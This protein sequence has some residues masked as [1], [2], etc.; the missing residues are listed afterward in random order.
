MA[1]SRSRKDQ[2]GASDGI[3]FMDRNRSPMG[4]NLNNAA[5]MYSTWT[6]F[7]GMPTQ[8]MTDTTAPQIHWDTFSPSSSP[9]FDQVY[10]NLD[11]NAEYL[12]QI[13]TNIRN[14][15][16]G[17]ETD[18]RLADH[19]LHGNSSFHEASME[20]QSMYAETL[21]SW[22]NVKN[23]DPFGTDDVLKTS[24]EPTENAQI[25]SKPSYSDIAKSLKSKP[26]Q[27][28]EKEEVDTSKKKSTEAH[29]GKHHK[30]FGRRG[31]HLQK[32]H[33][34]GHSTVA[35]DMES[36]VKPNSK[37]GLDNFDDVG[38]NEAGNLKSESLES[39]PLLSRKGSTSSVSSGTSG[40][41]E[42]HLSKGPTAG[43]KKDN[44]AQKTKVEGKQEKIQQSKPAE[45]TFFDPRRIFQQNKSSKDASKSSMDATVL[46]NGKPVGRSKSSSENHRK[47]SDYINNDLRDAKKR[48]NQSSSNKEAEKKENSNVSSVKTDKKQKNSSV[49]TDLHMTK[50]R[51]KHTRNSQHQYSFDQE[52][53]DEWVTY[54][55]EKTKSGI[56]YLWS[57]LVTCLLLLLGIVV[58]LVTFCVHIIT[59]TWGK[60]SM[61]VKTKL[62]KK[63][64]DKYS[65]ST[66]ESGSRIGL[67]ANIELPA[68]GEEAMQRLLACKGKDPYSILGLRYEVTDEEI[69]RYYKKQA[70]LVHP[71]KNTQP[72][73]EEAFKILGHAFELIGEPEQRRKYNCQ[74][75]EA[76]Q[77][78]AAMR[79]FNDLLANLHDKIQEAANLMRCDNCGGKH[80]RTPTDRPWYSAR[81]CKRCNIRHSAK[82]GDVWA[83]TSVFG[84]LWHYFACMEGKIYDITEWVSCKKDY[85]K[86]MQPNAHHVFY[87][88]ATE[89]G[90]APNNNQHQHGR[91]GEADLED[92]INHLFH[93]AM[94]TEQ[95]GNAQWQP[96]P[97]QTQP[98]SQNW[99][100]ANA[101]KKA[102]R[103]KKKH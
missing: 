92:F 99:G 39:I 79:E 44:S 71:D 45:K 86:H 98:S 14:N 82:E 47:S 32:Q 96:P 87:R 1:E 58:Y 76:T 102:R 17:I 11:P 30:G 80:K 74:M 60:A 57:A 73:A 52:Y 37:Y 19:S 88:I 6:Q 36:K 63:Y 67:E 83:E 21:S 13:L 2:H 7:S 70:V 81:F 101:A 64:F 24:Q 29:V 41:E 93:Q 48:T 77:A 59:W 51:S 72:G 38:N 68:T 89:G 84:F 43:S 65:T 33:S 53:I 28:K 18:P 31:S 40:I 10:T 15:P 66:Q 103:R 90:R 75:E 42:I 97:S 95:N 9:S 62:F 12:S 34:K 20:G 22:N 3:H 78:E 54:I 85:F 46:N 49:Q 55:L 25:R 100:A 23:Y 56:A 61:V 94:S 26:I 69:K 35:D 91:S 4:D 27:S 16:S 50:R 8:T 5:P